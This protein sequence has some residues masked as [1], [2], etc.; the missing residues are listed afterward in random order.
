MTADNLLDILSNPKLKDP[1]MLGN[2]ASNILNSVDKTTKDIDKVR[3]FIV[4]FMY[5]H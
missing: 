5:G 4:L 3:Y 2:M 1:A